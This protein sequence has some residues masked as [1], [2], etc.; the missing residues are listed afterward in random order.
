[1]RFHKEPERANGATKRRLPDNYI[2]IAPEESLIVFDYLN[3]QRQDVDEKLVAL[4]LNLCL[5]CQETADSLRVIDDAI[6]ER[7]AVALEPA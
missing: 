4:H 3:G 6:K 5:Q 7:L 1:M 2:C